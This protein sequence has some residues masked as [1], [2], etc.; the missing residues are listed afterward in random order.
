MPY[1]AKIWLNLHRHYAFSIKV[2]T[3]E[4]WPR[5]LQ[6]IR[7]CK[8]YLQMERR[9]CRLQ[10]LQQD[11]FP[12]CTYILA[13][14]RE[15]ILAQFPFRNYMEKIDDHMA[16]GTKEEMWGR[17]EREGQCS[18]SSGHYLFTSAP[19]LRKN[20]FSQHSHPLDSS[21]SDHTRDSLTPSRKGWPRTI[22]IDH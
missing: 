15:T 21:P 14:K 17:K 12:P 10:L 19:E 2:I 1:K 20:T 7:S 16:E 5:R 9:I 3:K 4:T 11:N 22:L 8:M 6:S 18:S 13:R